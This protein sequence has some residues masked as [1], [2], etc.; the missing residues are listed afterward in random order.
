M[1]KLILHSPESY[2]KATA[3]QLRTVCN[4]CGPKSLPGWVV[5]DTL[6]GLSITSA[7]NIHDWMCD[8]SENGTDR[9]E[10]DIW[11]L[12]NMLRIVEAVG[13]SPLTPL[14][15][16]RAMTYYSA[17]YDAGQLRWGEKG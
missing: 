16:H 11:F 8:E 4:G 10:A 1:K 13:W 2:K 3:A 7:C 12:I 14:R 17:V 9:E 5:P 6:W 15:R